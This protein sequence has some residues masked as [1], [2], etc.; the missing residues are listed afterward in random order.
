MAI[1]SYATL[2]T[3]IEAWSHRSDLAAVVDDFID[4]TESRLNRELRVSQQETVTTLTAV[5]GL[6]D[7]PADFL[8][9]RT[10]SI[11][12][13][14]VRELHY[15]SPA[16]FDKFNYT[17]EVRQY[18]IVG[19]KIKLNVAGASDVVVTYYAKIAALSDTVAT[20]WVLDTHPEAYL[21][22]CLSEVFK[23]SMDEEQAAKYA[24]L[25]SQSVDQIQRLN[26]DRKTGQAMRVRA[27]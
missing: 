26:R 9:I 4:I 17:D 7:L 1:T 6:I 13:N 11:N 22:G 21:Y 10:V 15:V 24:G 12:S 27:A 16:E 18:T 5:A 8:A 20:N 14:P 19:D 3:A 2:K 25:Y 23:Y